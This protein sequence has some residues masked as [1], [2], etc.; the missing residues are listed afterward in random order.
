V[1]RTTAKDAERFFQGPKNNFLKAA[2]S[3]LDCFQM[4]LGIGFFVY[5]TPRPLIF[6]KTPVSIGEKSPSHSSTALGFP[7]YM[8]STKSKHVALP[9]HS[10]EFPKQARPILLCNSRLVTLTRQDVDI[11]ESAEIVDIGSG[12]ESFYRHKHSKIQV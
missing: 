2:L 1:T 6:C 5:R 9:S 10:V 12:G 3:C 4:M 7:S 8:Q 11:R